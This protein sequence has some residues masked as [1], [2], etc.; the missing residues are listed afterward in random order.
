[1]QARSAVS[2]RRF[3]IAFALIALAC[4]REQQ[5]APTPAPAPVQPRDGGTLTRRLENEVT[6]LNYL[7]HT[8]DYERNVLAYLYDPLID[9]DENLQPIP[10]TAASWTVSPDR[11]TYTLKLDPRSTFSDGKP[12]RASD[13][14]F[15]IRK[16]IEAESMQYSSFFTGLDLNRLRALDDRTVEVV[17]TEPHVAR[18]YAFNI[19][20][21]PE[22][23][24]G[25]GDFKNDFNDMAVGNGPY[26]L[27]RRQAEQPITLER[28]ADYW[29]EKPHIQRIV[30]KVI[31]DTTVAWNAMK[32][33][34]IDEM[35]LKTD[36]WARE[37]N[38]PNVEFHDVWALQYNCIAWNNRDPILRDPRVRR[39]LAMAFDTKQVIDTMYH[40]QARAISGPFTPDQWAYNAAVPPV[41]FD[42][43]GARK[44]L[45]EAGWKDKKLA[46][47]MILPAGNTVGLEQGQILQDALGKIG[48]TLSVQA[49]E[50]A[51][52]F[53]HIMRGNYQSAF[54][55]WSLDPEPDLYPL[56]HSTQ[57]PPAGMNV[58]GYSNPE[59]DRAIDEAR[60]TF[61]L[62][63]R[64]AAYHRLHV[65]LAADQP[66]LWTL[67]LAQKWAVNKR[68]KNVKVSKGFG[69]FIWHPGP[70]QWWLQ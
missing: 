10:G 28:R 59:V 61:D 49:L 56:F 6:T 37:K 8:T 14:V 33:G 52:F 4:G 2:I 57:I 46:L 40:G 38:A 21:L 43:A 1:M 11:L 3:F 13:I 18:W 42:L 15:T 50:G 62:P 51:A 5:R 58:I 39:A 23:V 44:L 66:Y 70:K 55:A 60:R 63:T 9:L 19:G 16:I 17:F 65:M 69:L 34:D 25:K 31:G 29:R 68:V 22:H 30:F 7:L 48:V 35:R 26:V 27:A 64:R 12:V 20:V 41:K 67:Q 32:R 36:F 47:T 45:D 53:E 54:F 24:Y